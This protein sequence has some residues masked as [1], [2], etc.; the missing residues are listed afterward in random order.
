MGDNLTTR[1]VL[2]N[3][4]ARNTRGAEEEINVYRSQLHVKKTADVLLLW[5]HK[6]SGSYDKLVEA[7]R[8]LAL[9]HVA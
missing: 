6:Q 4:T 3:E 1:L 2:K 5:L 7:S 9:Q 8:Q